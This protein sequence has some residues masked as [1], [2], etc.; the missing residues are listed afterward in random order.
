MI[1]ISLEIKKQVY[2]QEMVCGNFSVSRVSVTFTKTPHIH[3]YSLETKQN[4][5][6]SRKLPPRGN[7]RGFLLLL[8]SPGRLPTPKPVTSGNSVADIWC[9]IRS[10][11]SVN[12]RVP[13]LRHWNSHQACFQKLLNVNE[14]IRKGKPEL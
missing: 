8:L 14:K 4:S 2:N 9:K 6:L 13:F 5:V 7:M 10:I 12:V 11:F 1:G 3:V